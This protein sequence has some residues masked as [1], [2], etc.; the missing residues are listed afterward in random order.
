MNLQNVT[1]LIFLVLFIGCVKDPNQPPTSP[2]SPTPSVSDKAIIS[3]GFKVSDNPG[4]LSSDFIGII[5]SDS[6]LISLPSGTNAS[7]LKPS[8]TFKGKSISPAASVGQDFTKEVSY[9]VSAIDGSTKK[10]IVITTILPPNLSTEKS[11]TAFRFKA[12]ANP[13]ILA[14]DVIGNI[15]N[16]SIFLNLPIGTNTVNL[17]PDISYTGINIT[18]ASSGSRNFSYPVSYT[19]TAQ[20]GSL[21]IYT[22]VVYVEPLNATIYVGGSAQNVTGPKEQYFYAINANT[23][24]LKW[25]IQLPVGC[26]VS[27]P[28]YYNG[29]VYANDGADLLAIDTTNGSIKWR[30]KTGGWI[31]STPSIVNGIL[32]FNSSDHVLYALDAM[33][34]TLKWKFT[35]QGLES[36][37]RNGSSPTIVNGVVYIGSAVHKI[38]ALDANTGAIIWEVGSPSFSDIE[39]SPSVVNG[40]VYISD[41]YNLLALNSVDGSLKWSYPLNFSLSN[42]TVVNGI[43]Y[44][45]SE[46]YLYAIDANTGIQL[47]NRYTGN[48]QYS[49]KLFEGVLYLSYGAILA[50]DPLTGLDIWYYIPSAFMGFQAEPV[51][52]NRTIYSPN[53]EHLWAIDMLTKKLKWKFAFVGKEE[54]FIRSSCVVDEKGNVYRPTVSGDEN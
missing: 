20:D 33:T 54:N 44:I 25:K 27:S 53:T 47:W 45:G 52:Y 16:D 48:G 42:P 36:S 22:I 6:I 14:S 13:G 49:V 8:I 4:L 2:T 3:F 12:S 34:G 51:I 30:Y 37:G 1:A 50:M 35:Q 10:Y 19:I 23:G 9:S 43:V 5:N 32:Y 31:Y 17:T 26:V 24:V 28:A 11:I 39:S 7:S 29:I 15:R 38:Y 41:T 46:H 21:K 40:V 18:P